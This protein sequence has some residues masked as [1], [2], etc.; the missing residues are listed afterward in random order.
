[1]VCLNPWVQAGRPVGGRPLIP[2]ALIGANPWVRRALDLGERGLIPWVHAFVPWDQGGR[3]RVR[4]GLNP[5][6]AWEAANATIA[7]SRAAS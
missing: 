7:P 1:M 5:T 6:Q 4:P 3:I 2:W